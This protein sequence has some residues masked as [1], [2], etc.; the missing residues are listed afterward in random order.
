MLVIPASTASRIERVRE[1]ILARRARLVHEP[2]RDRRLEALGHE[3]LAL[4]AG[5]GHIRQGEIL[6]GDG[7]DPHGVPGLLGEPREPALDHGPHAPGDIAADAR[8]QHVRR[9]G[10]MRLDQVAHELLDEERVAA[11]APVDGRDELGRRS[12][13]EPR[14]SEI[15]RLRLREPCQLHELEAPLAAQVVEQRVQA[16]GHLAGLVAQGADHEQR[17]PY[18]RAD[19]V[20][21]HLERGRVGPVQVL[22]DEQDRAPLSAAADHARDRLEEAVADIARIGLP[23][24]RSELGQKAGELRGHPPGKRCGLTADVMAERLGERRERDHPV[25]HAAAG[26]HLRPARAHLA[27]ECGEEA[28]LPAARLA[29]HHHDVGRARA[30]PLPCGAQ[31][32]ELV[33]PADQRRVV[34]ARERRRQRQRPGLPRSRL[35][36]RAQLLDQRAS[37]GRRRHAV[38][39][40]QARTERFVG[41]DAR[42]GVARAPQPLD[43]RTRRLLGRGL[44]IEPATREA[45][46]GLRVARLLRPCAEDVQ[47]RSHT[48]AVNRALLEHPVVVQIG[49]EVAAGELQRCLQATFCA[50]PLG[51]P[52][53]DPDL[54]PVLDAHPIAAGVDDGG[55]LV[56]GLPAQRRQRRPQAGPGAALEHVGPEHR[57][58]PR[59]RVQ[60]GVVR[61]PR[62]E[63][64]R[65]LARD[66]VE[67]T[68]VH[69]EPELADE[70]HPQHPGR[71]YPTP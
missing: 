62:Q 15:A 11:R 31:R 7:R 71:P 34:T 17:C 21:E 19:D 30:R 18:H 32:R 33:F 16:G 49:Q 12:L 29:G 60:A 50:Q 4:L 63:R 43:E 42:R 37:L 68:L 35:R 38:L 70:S 67:R 55:G 6:P 40:P 27:R 14:R 59:A 28:R 54:R 41:R 3:L 8:G 48:V 23:R 39:A 45:S 58:D 47:D 46:G 57:R 25:L 64:P 44:E 10:A 1:A 53:I 13:P 20:R 56:A 2:R 61:Q 65:P 5:P 9:L 22:D 52:D 36:R 26:E 69:V 66:G 24:P 51:L